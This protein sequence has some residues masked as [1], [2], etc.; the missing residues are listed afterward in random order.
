MLKQ[1]ITIKMI[2]FKVVK[3]GEEKM[4]DELVSIIIP[5]YNAEKYLEEC[6][7]SVVNQTYHNLEIILIDDGST[8]KSGKIC[9]EYAQKDSRI[10]VI[11]KQNEGISQARNIGIEMAKGE[12]IQFVDS[13]DYVDL[14]LV[15]TAYSLARKNEADIVCFSHYTVKESENEIIQESED[16]LKVLS[17]MEA[18]KELLLDRK[19]RNFPW[20]K[21]WKR[22]LF[23]GI[24]FPVG[25][26]Y[27]D[28][29][30]CGKMF[31]KANKVVYYGCP[32]YYYRL[33]KGSISHT[34]SPELS[35]YYINTVE[36]MA[37][38]LRRH[39]EL[40]QYCDFSIV[41]TVV[42]IH[43]DM[44]IYNIE[45]LENNPRIIEAYNKIKQIMKNKE[46]ERT[47]I[48]NMDIVFKIHTYYLLFNR[49]AY[50]KNY[51]YLPKLGIEQVY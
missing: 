5:V 31:E 3:M 8:D 2:S 34:P 42:R 32:K 26:P 49:N 40:E 47:I 7:E 25:K 39:K 20:E 36:E 27:E 11:H 6:L 35:I 18:L 38:H 13:D 30:T 21:L 29:A 45:N 9:D 51:K 14:D 48:E 50:M 28:I 15:E 23:D 17:P 44:A 24:V 46:T 33:R 1:K 4:K 10:K 16:I 37:N 41:S 43:N 22:K 12:Y 19:I